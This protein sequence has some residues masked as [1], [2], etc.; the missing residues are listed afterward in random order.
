MKITTNH[1]GSFLNATRLTTQQS[2][3]AV[4]RTS[5]NT[6]RRD[7]LDIGN[8][9]PPFQ[10][11]A[12][13]TADGSVRDSILNTISQTRVGT[14][15][16][17]LTPAFAAITRARE[18]I[19][20][21]NY[22]TMPPE[23]VWPILDRL[24][25][26]IQNTDF[27]EMTA[28]QIYKFVESKFTEAFGENF[29]MGLHLLGGIPFDGDMHDA[30]IS[31]NSNFAYLQIGINFN[32]WVNNLIREPDSFFEVNRERLFGGKT[33]GEI[34]DALKARQ[35]QPLT[36]RGLAIVAGE[37]YSVGITSMKISG[38]G[39]VVDTLIGSPTVRPAGELMPPWDEMEANWN[40]QLDRPAGRA[41]SIMQ[42]AQN[43]HMRQDDNM[44][45]PELLRLRD[46]LVHFGGVLGT[47]GLFMPDL[48]DELFEM[49]GS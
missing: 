42:A 7:T 44:G 32:A 21:S 6:F 24:S 29:M 19:D 35:P 47:D 18:P 46:L 14:P 31:K 48:E 49:L 9:S 20:F 34:V 45:N 27:S 16:A 8:T 13:P 1:I 39:I 4:G 26:E 30:G 2:P 38:M 23:E 10:H 36:N 41:L 15:Q 3:S 37:L 17:F 43:E 22:Y 5:A 25:D 33:D 40:R 28:L 11:Y 12:S